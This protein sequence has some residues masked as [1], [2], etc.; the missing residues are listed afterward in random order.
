MYLN[1]TPETSSPER[2]EAAKFLHDRFHLAVPV[3]SKL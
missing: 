1:S 2:D 3:A